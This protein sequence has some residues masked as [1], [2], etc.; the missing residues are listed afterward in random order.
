MAFR[1]ERYKRDLGDFHISCDTEEQAR[2]IAYRLNGH[3]DLS[4]SYTVD[5]P[6]DPEA[7]FTVVAS[8]RPTTRESAE[9]RREVAK[10]VGYDGHV[11]FG[12]LIDNEEDAG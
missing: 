7:G 5:N 1:D 9:L 12:G 3:E 6:D 2:D 4:A 8:V 10:L 11:L